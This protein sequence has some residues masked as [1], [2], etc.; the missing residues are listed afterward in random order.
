MATTLKIVETYNN[1]IEQ[2]QLAYDLSKAGDISGAQEKLE[3]AAS[4]I[5]KAIEWGVKNY[6]LEK[7]PDKTKFPDEFKIIEGN[8]FHKKFDLFSDNAN[9]SLNAKSIEPKTIKEL[10]QIVRNDP[11]HSG[12]VPHY[13]SLVK[14]VLEAEKIIQCYIAPTAHLKKIPSPIEIVNVA[15]DKSWSEFYSACD[16]FGRDKNQILIIGPTE[17]FSKDKL[18]YLGLLDWS[19]IIDFDQN[20]EIDGFYKYGRGFLEGRKKIHLLTSEDGLSFSPYN[21]AYWFAANGLNGRQSTLTKDFKVWNRK[22]FAFLSKLFSSFFQIFGDKPTNVI[23]LWDDQIYIQKICEFIDSINGEKTEFIYAIEKMANLSSVIDVYEGKCVEI[24]IPKIA[25]G[26]LNVRNF[27]NSELGKDI[28]TLPAMDQE[29]VNVDENDFLWIEEDLEVLHLNILDGVD[30]YTIGKL[31][32]EKFYKGNQISWLSL[33]LHHD[34]ARDKTNSIKK[35]VEKTLRERLTEKIIL[36]HHP[37]VGGSTICRRIAWDLKDDY[38]VLL[39]KKYRPAN[40]IDKIYKIFDLTKQT[41]LLVAD[42]SAVNI[43]EINKLFEELLSRNFPCVCFIVQRSDSTKETSFHLA[44]ILSDLEFQTFLAKYKELCPTKQAALTKISQSK[45]KVERHPFYLGLTAYEEEFNGLSNFVERNLIDTS[46][47]Q[48]KA[49]SIIAL[50]YYYGQKNTSAQML[51]TLLMTSEKMVV[52]LERHLNKNLLSLLIK[53]EEVKWRPVHYLVAQE[54]LIQTLSGDKN[55]REFWK[56]NLLDL[57]RNLIQLIAAK[58]SIPSDNEMELLKRLFVYRN[59]Q[60]ILGKEEESVFS[61]FIENGLQTDEARLSIFKQLTESFPDESHFWAHL[62]RFFSLRMKNHSEALNAISKAIDLSIGKDSLLYHMKGMCLR[63]IA[64]DK[65]REFQGVSEIPKEVVKEIFSKVDEA[66]EFFE[67]CRN[68]NPSNEYGYVSHIQMLI[69]VIDFG[70]SIS[71]ITSKTEFLRNLDVWF[72]E[73][74][75]LA[76][77]LLDLMKLQAQMRNNNS[78][79]DECDLKLQELYENFSLVIEGWNNLL[80]KANKDK[81]VIRRS[82]VRAYVRRAQSWDS[83]E[84]KDIDKIIKLIEENIQEEP[85]KANNI[86]LWFQ[87]ARQTEKIDVNSAIEKVSNWRT[88]SDMNESLYY[89]S[90][91]HTI[92]AIE[93]TSISKI[94]AEKL[95]RELSERKRNTPFRTHCLE[96]FGKRSGLKRIVPYKN[97]ISR[98]DSNEMVI[99]T[100]LLEKIRGKISYIKGPEGGTI[101]LACGLTAN[102]IP[103]R[104]IGFS[105]DKDIN[106][107]VNFYLGFS[108]DGLR[109]YEV[110]P[111]N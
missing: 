98:N 74:L 23:V 25:A 69:S 58:S 89:L 2:I 91:L 39:L 106:R 88:I 18:G 38:P 30:I 52:I 82:I 11:E 105:R 6:L 72:Q 85:D 4:C 70:F 29:F 68:I 3:T 43:D 97:A 77:D 46:P 66:G 13:N 55:R 90:V 17:G 83:I 63:A 71:K 108:N 27:F 95:I 41:I 61:N 54:L 78:Y 80:S 81:S 28:F 48:Q 59:N 57:A 7:F 31:E 32:R 1:S 26:I 15:G 101:E 86:Y 67:E 33:Q 56:N 40:T 20:T 22:H 60:E 110:E 62:A 65:M 16:S 9:P 47:V 14:V 10:K 45:E 34:I 76:E 42:A 94:K 75:D 5:Y 84:N 100:E 36:H 111:F 73:K 93:G 24:A 92:Q 87:A 21:S 44:D 79:L 37:G 103:A 96:W 8:N 64:R 53:E 19:L 12:Y 50:C 109:A 102:F 107:N 99:N 51:S 49:I 35:K 104:G